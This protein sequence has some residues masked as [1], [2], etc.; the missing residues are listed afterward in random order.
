[1]AS[2]YGEAL[3]PMGWQA[4]PL[5]VGR[6]GEQGKLEGMIAAQDA[7]L[8]WS[9]G[10]SD[11]TLFERGEKRVERHRFVRHAGMLDFLPRGSVLEEIRWRGQPSECLSVQFDPG[12]VQR[13][14]GTQAEFA[15]DALRT[16]VSDGHILDLVTRLREQAALGMP[17][18]SLYVEALAL[19]L[20]TYVYGKYSQ[21]PV[22]PSGALS[23][24]AAQSA[25]LTAYVE[26]HLSD[27]LSLCDLSRVVGYSPDH[28]ARLF[29]RSFGVPPYQYVLARRVERAK[30]LLR[31]RACSIAE[32]A[33]LCGFASQAHLHSAF[34]A[35]TGAT[36][37]AFRR[38]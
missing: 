12:V 23:L 17:L 32:V 21:R 34:K 5:R 26:D 20:A 9:G 4:W 7:V 11:V 8:V 38:G 18:G 36:P 24:S 3:T 2:K 25:E 19:T 29:K 16:A 10:R 13:L 15:P 14:L 1:M 35:R 22:P 31:G 6:F 27:N 37:G 28:F 33:M 30:L